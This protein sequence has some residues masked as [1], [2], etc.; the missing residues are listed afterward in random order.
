ME[1]VNLAVKYRPQTLDDVVGQQHVVS[2]LK[3]MFSKGK[4]PNSFLLTGPTGLG[5]T[6]L[7]RIIA[8]YINCEKPD[9]EKHA[10]C[11]ECHN[12]EFEQDHPDVGEILS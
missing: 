8:R 4:M 7:A 2:Q 11:G 9:T 10:P 6:T 1:T 5:K 3:G 12:C